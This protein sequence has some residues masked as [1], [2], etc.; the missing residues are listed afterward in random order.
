MPPFYHVHMLTETV[1][2][3][4]Q[5]TRHAKC[6]NLYKRNENN[7][8]H[9]KRQIFNLAVILNKLNQKHL[10]N[11]HGKPAPICENMHCDVII[12][13]ISRDTKNYCQFLKQV[14]FYLIAKK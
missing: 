8:Y 13:E 6:L 14:K 11:S 4:K 1:N 9:L 7:L 3:E 5:V 2:T 12:Q 10:R